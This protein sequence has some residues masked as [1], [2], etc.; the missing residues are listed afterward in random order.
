MPNKYNHKKNI[1][2]EVASSKNKIQSGDIVFFNYS[3]K[4][5]TTPRPMV[6]VL[7]PNWKGHLHGLNLDYIPESTLKKLWEL[8]K[9][10]VAGKI[11]RL[12]KLRLPLLKADIGNP[13]A[14]YNSRLKGFL[15]GSLGKTGVAYRTY[16]LSGIGSMKKVDYRFEG[17]SFA[18]E[19]RQ[20]AE[21]LK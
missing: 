14:F 17:S 18:D 21:D 4:N 20:Q 5:V 7:H 11:E 13:K 3:G 1:L 2:N 6:L 8:T 15:R 19:V 9:V 10:T 12:T 16:T